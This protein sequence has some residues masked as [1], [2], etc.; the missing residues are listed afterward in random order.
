MLAFTRQSELIRALLCT[1]TCPGQEPPRMSARS[2]ANLSAL[3]RLQEWLFA[4]AWLEMDHSLGHKTISAHDTKVTAVCVVP[5]TPPTPQSQLVTIPTSAPAPPAFE[6]LP[7][8]IL[9]EAEP[10]PKH[11]ESPPAASLSSLL[12]PVVK[13]NDYA[14]HNLP[15]PVMGYFASLDDMS[16][17]HRHEIVRIMSRK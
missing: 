10:S 5:W 8:A 12:N 17:Q 6:A 15:G 11:R 13:M 9:T 2:A 3:T 4:P 16:G 7:S 14:L 1:R